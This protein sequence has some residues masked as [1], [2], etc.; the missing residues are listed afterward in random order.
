[1]RRKVL[2]TAVTTLAMCGALATDMAHK[3]KTIQE[4]VT[5][6]AGTAE[7]TCDNPGGWT[8]DRF[9]F[10][11]DRYAEQSSNQAWTGPGGCQM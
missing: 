11:G 4:V 10:G 1:M 8:F 2:V 5:R 7:V 9:E 6:H 3:A